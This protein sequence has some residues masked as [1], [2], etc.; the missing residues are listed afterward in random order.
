ME[1]GGEGRTTWTEQNE[2]KLK[3]SRHKALLYSRYEGRS[4]IAGISGRSDDECFACC[5]LSSFS[6]LSLASG[7]TVSSLL[8]LLLLV[9]LLLPLPT[10]TAARA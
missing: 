4:Y 10:T 9:L 1:E 8:Q 3:T 2:P 7:E 5:L 6:L